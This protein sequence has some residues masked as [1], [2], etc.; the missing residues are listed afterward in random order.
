MNILN[1]AYV[2]RSS[3]GAVYYRYYLVHVPLLQKNFVHAFA[4]TLLNWNSF[5]GL[6]KQE[7]KEFEYLY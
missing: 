7:E 4:T 1:I 5:H 6:Y 2:F 3:H